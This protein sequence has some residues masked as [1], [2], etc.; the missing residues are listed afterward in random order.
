MN[1]QKQ[2]NKLIILYNQEQLSSENTSNV[3]IA[4]AAEKPSDKTKEGLS[5]RII[6]NEAQ[7][8]ANKSMEQ[9][10]ED[11]NT[12][13]MEIAKVSEVEISET[14]EIENT[15]ITEMYTVQAN[16]GDDNSHSI[17]SV[18]I[19]DNEENTGSTYEDGY[20]SDSALYP[21][22]SDAQV[23]EVSESDM[24]T[25]IPAMN[26]TP[27]DSNRRRFEGKKVYL[28]FDDGP[29]VNTDD[30][31]DI[32]ND[33]GVK[34]TFFVTGKTDSHSI[35]MYKRI[36]EEG[37]TLGM[38]SYSHKYDIIYKSVEDFD[39]DFTKLRDLLYDTTGLEPKIY[40]FPGGSG[41]KV[42]KRGMSE[43]IRYLNNKNIVYYDWNVLNGDATNIK[44]TDEQL[45]ANVLSG[46]EKKTISIVLMH[47]SASK[48]ATVRTLPELLEKL[49]SGGAELYP[50]DP[51][52]KP[53]QMIRADSIK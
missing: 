15:K 19:Y 51:S 6:D 3:N 39:K 34:A 41:N 23:S 45:I 27:A 14:S 46:V 11:V 52:V 25:D 24:N 35:S 31:L 48:E 13:E 18:N 10:A 42:S 1:L 4:Y 44:Y 47:D 22:S 16:V 20:K 2:V 50:L 9:I 32:L 37:H 43:F 38:H 7:A 40:R 28:T 53:I 33:Y 8:D 30:I 36:V 17:N 21:A 5:D 12:P 26:A 49:I 29:S